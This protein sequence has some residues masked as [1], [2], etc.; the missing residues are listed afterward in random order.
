MSKKKVISSGRLEEIV[1]EIVNNL[2][3]RKGFSHAE[4]TVAVR[5]AISELREKVPWQMI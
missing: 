4:I 5:Q 2:P 1:E 3:P